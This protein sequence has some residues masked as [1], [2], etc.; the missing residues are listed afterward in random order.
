MLKSWHSNP[1]QRP[2]MEYLHSQLESCIIRGPST[3]EA[4]FTNELTHNT[5]DPGIPA[6]PLPDLY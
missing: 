5:S 2:R 3:I 4:H 1:A 6:N